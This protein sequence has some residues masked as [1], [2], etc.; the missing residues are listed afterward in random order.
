LAP[1]SLLRSVGIL[2]SGVPTLAR[3]RTLLALRLLSRSVG[4]LVVVYAHPRPLSCTPSTAV[5]WL[6]SLVVAPCAH[7]PSP[8]HSQCCCACSP[9]LAHSRRCICSVRILG[10]GTMCLLALSHTLPAPCLLLHLVGILGGGALCLLT[11][12]QPCVYFRTQLESLVV[13]LHARPCP[14][15]HTPTPC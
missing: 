12:S 8:T 15:S 9:S 6:G 5:A 10:S 2:S 4:I 11:F 1:R 3:S 14:I 13:V 7:S